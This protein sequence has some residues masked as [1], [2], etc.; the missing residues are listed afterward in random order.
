MSFNILE[1]R[2]QVSLSHK[3][4]RKG[5]VRVRKGG[6]RAVQITLVSTASP[7]PV[8]RTP[9]P[10]RISPARALHRIPSFSAPSSPVRERN[11]PRNPAAVE[12]HFDR[13][14]TTVVPVSAAA[15]AA[16]VA[17]VK[18][19]GRV[20][21][22]VT[23][24][25]RSAKRLPAGTVLGIARKV[26]TDTWGKKKSTGNSEEDPA[27][28]VLTDYLHLKGINVD[29]FDGDVLFWLTDVAPSVRDSLKK[30]DEIE[31]TVITRPFEDSTDVFADMAVDIVRTR[32]HR[33]PNVPSG[34]PPKWSAGSGSTSKGGISPV[35]PAGE[36]RAPKF[37]GISSVVVPGPE[38][39]A[40]GFAAGRGKPL[41]SATSGPPSSAGSLVGTA[42]TTIGFSGAFGSAETSPKLTPI[43]VGRGANNSGKAAISMAAANPLPAL[44]ISTSAFQFKD[45]IAAQAFIP[46]SHSSD[47]MKGAGSLKAGTGATGAS[48]PRTPRTPR[49]PLASIVNSANSN[50]VDPRFEDAEAR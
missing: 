37:S 45:A 3:A 15:A 47:S 46:K 29:L 42:P 10:V 2:R 40:I 5:G 21:G 11:V 26:E 20:R 35:P 30:R 39:G 43:A 4:E 41:S 25:I 50:Y 34:A 16:L 44:P 22:T 19:G 49:S 23:R 48:T 8:N 7:P 1:D 27:R 33:P 24:L 13:A 17:S 38:K 18:P 6:R 9:T 12:A 32:S 14:E 28:R 31:Y 36:R